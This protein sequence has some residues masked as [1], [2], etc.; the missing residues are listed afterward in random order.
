[1]I[2]GHEHLRFMPSVFAVG[3]EYQIFSIFD[4]SATV[5][6]RVGNE[7]FYDDF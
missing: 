1:M 3:D 5:K 7:E 2:N 4:C 6:V